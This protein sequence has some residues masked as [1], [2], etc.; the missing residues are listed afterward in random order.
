[1]YVGDQIYRTA[2]FSLTEIAN[3]MKD[4]LDAGMHL[5]SMGFHGD[6]YALMDSNKILVLGAPSIGNLSIYLE[7]RI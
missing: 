7:G 4:T 1:L 5:E 2:C 3:L 6:K